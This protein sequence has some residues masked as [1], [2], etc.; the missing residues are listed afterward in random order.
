[1]SKH[2]THEVAPFLT[3][4]SNWD[5]QTGLK[6][7]QYK[8]FQFT[9]PWVKQYFHVTTGTTSA[10]DNAEDTLA[11]TV[12]GAVGMPAA[13]ANYLVGQKVDV[14]AVDANDKPTGAPKGTTFNYYIYINNFN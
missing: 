1:M 2:A 12:T 9:S 10:A 8:L 4:V 11:V 7:P 14:Y 6:D 3:A 5:Q 13:L